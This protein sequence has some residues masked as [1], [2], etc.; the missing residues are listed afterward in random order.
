MKRIRTQSFF[1][2][3]LVFV[4]VIA[5]ILSYFVWKMPNELGIK[6]DSRLQQAWFIGI[7]I[8]SVVFLLIMGIYYVATRKTGE[9]SFEELRQ[10]ISGDDKKIEPVETQ[11]PESIAALESLSFRLHCRYG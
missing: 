8:S 11:L 6:A 3:L 2:L 9:L 1:W 4:L 10:R 7:A 5:A